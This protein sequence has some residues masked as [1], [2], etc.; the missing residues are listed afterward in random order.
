MT[1]QTTPTVH[2][3]DTSAA[4][5]ASIVSIGRPTI[6][7]IQNGR[8]YLQTRGIGPDV[9]RAAEHQRTISYSPGTIRFMGRD[10]YSRA[11]L[12][13]WLDFDYTS[14]SAGFTMEGSDLSFPVVFSCSTNCVLIVETNMEAL[15]FWTLARAMHQEPPTIIVNSGATSGELFKRA[16]VHGLLQQARKVIIVCERGQSIDEQHQVN[17]KHLE[18]QASV[19]A[20]IQD[21]DRV[22]LWCLQN[23]RNIAGLMNTVAAGFGHAQPV[24]L[25]VPRNQA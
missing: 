1:E 10:T 4:P 14:T 15:S 20:I 16:H 17:R 5:S 2:T 8:R 12:V 24:Q 9:V 22:Q 13:T 6:D 25:H 7:D 3:K 23:T 19:E 18:Q 21:R 11:R